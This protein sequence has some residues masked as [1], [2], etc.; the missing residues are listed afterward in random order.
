MSATATHVQPPLAAQLD[1][2]GAGVGAEA[3][4]PRVIGIDLSLTATG[5]SDGTRTWL[6]KSKGAKTATLLERYHRLGRI[7]GTL[8]DGLPQQ[9]ALAVVEGPSFG[10]QRQG[11]Q[12]DRAGLWWYIVSSLLDL[13]VSV[14]EIPP[15]SLKTYATGKGNGSK[16]EVLAA[17]VRRYPDVEVTDNNT[18]DALVLAAMGLRH[19]GHPI[20][21][22]PLTHLRAMSKVAWPTLANEK[23]PF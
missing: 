18:A 6:V 15:A 20:D 2:P 13:G 12:H 10:Q 9:P 17:V 16:D 23:V 4:P 22:L 21:D 14:A 11:G 3:A 7:H 1:G 5:I 19:L 8:L